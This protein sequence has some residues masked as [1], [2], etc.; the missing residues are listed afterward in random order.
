MAAIGHPLLGEGKYSKSNDKKMGF[1]KQALYS[2]SLKFDFKTD[3]GILNYLNGKRFTVDNVWF[4]DELFGDEYKK[5][6]K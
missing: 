5:L 1:D 3:A 2:Y 6:L 4:A